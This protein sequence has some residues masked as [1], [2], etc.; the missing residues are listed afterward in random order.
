MKNRFLY[1]LMLLTVVSASSFSQ[2]KN[3]KRPNV[4]LIMA[5]DMGYE[6]VAAN[7]CTEYETPNLDRI[8]ADG[9]NFS[10]CYSQPLCTP[11]RVK[12]M[13]G[14]YNMNNYE[15]FEYLPTQEY[16]FGNLMQDAGYKTCI[17]GKWQLNGAISK[18]AGSDDPKRPTKLGFDEFMLWHVTK[19]KKEKGGVP[20]GRFCQP[21]IN[22][23]GVTKSYSKEEYGPDLFY[24]YAKGFIKKNKDNPFF[25]YYPM[26]L[27][28]SPFVPTPD[29][30]EWKDLKT[31]TKSDTAY[32][33][34]MV[35]Y[36][37]K[38]VGKIEQDLKDNG[39]YENTIIIFTG[40]N[41]CHNDIYTDTKNGVVRGGK[42]YPISSGIHV[43]MIASW[44][45]KGVKAK[46]NDLISFADF[47]PTFAEIVDKEV[48]TD[49]KSFLWA[50]EGR[51]GERNESVLITYDPHWGKGEKI[52]CYFALDGK[53][54]LYHDGE[55]FNYQKDPLEKKDLSKRKELTKEQQVAYAVLKKELEKVKDWRPSSEA[56][57][58]KRP[59]VKKVGEKKGEKKKLTPEQ[60]EKKKAK[61]AARRAKLGIN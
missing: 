23:N 29:S 27:T 2:K 17:V 50:L 22:T 18:Q 7:G 40:D 12:I 52:R 36:A 49:G 58:I 56:K 11:S 43:P 30:P 61:K 8:A 26:V 5:D 37:D 51:E 57:R 59:T 46:S 33:A 10:K 31:R 28:H 54:K 39:I 4:I 53:Y 6:A 34:D 15:A 21:L 20:H 48:E 55:F 3:D 32:F 13:T 16:N 47:L 9:I 41:G 45:A 38:I 1:V 60:K 44:P 19:D 25:L 35:K 42:W 14:K 24:N